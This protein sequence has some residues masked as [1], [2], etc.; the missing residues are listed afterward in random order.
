MTSSMALTTFIQCFT[1]VLLHI[2]LQLLT[3]VNRHILI[4]FILTYIKSIEVTLTHAK[5]ILIRIMHVYLTHIS[6]CPITLTDDKSFYY[7]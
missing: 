2:I 7:M 4:P 5:V 6:K 1:F 3:T